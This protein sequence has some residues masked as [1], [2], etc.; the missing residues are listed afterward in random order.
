MAAFNVERGNGN[1]KRERVMKSIIKNVLRD[2]Q[3][4]ETI[5]YAFILGLIILAAMSLV[6]AFGSKVV[7][8]WTSLN[9]GFH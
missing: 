9:S 5:E 8:K 3:G 6:G 4:T 1:Q 2:E 7:A